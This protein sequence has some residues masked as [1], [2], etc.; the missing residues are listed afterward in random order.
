MTTEEKYFAAENK[1]WRSILKRGTKIKWNW[2]QRSS[3]QRERNRPFARKT[4]PRFLI[5]VDLRYFSISV[6]YDLFVLNLIGFVWKSL[7]D[8]E[9]PRKKRYP[10]ERK[11]NFHDWL[12]YLIYFF[13]FNVSQNNNSASCSSKVKENLV[14]WYLNN[15]KLK[16]R[17]HLYS[18]WITSLA[19]GV[20]A[21]HREGAVGEIHLNCALTSNTSAETN[22]TISCRLE[23][24]SI[25]SIWN[26]TF[27]FMEFIT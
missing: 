23:G 1:R 25:L 18:R 12:H 26:Y 2:K 7:F 27:I 19:E 3:S 10:S 17:I 4:K 20:H 22:N 24:T 15:M 9:C 6:N 5:P 16:I 11:V 21:Y 13:S 14:Q 8:W